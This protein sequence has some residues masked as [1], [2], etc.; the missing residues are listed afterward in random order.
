MTASLSLQTLL[1]ETLRDDIATKALVAGRVY[2][3]VP[4]TPTFPYISFG[5][6]DYQPDDADCIAG[7]THTIQID[8]WSRAVGFPECKNICDAVKKALHRRPLN[9][10]EASPDAVV[11]INVE[12]VRSLRD[13]DGTTSHGIITVAVMIEEG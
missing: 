2:D 6:T 10:G 8:V 4:P 3:R 12:S 5:P 7:G 1:Y 13:S 11:E 9:F